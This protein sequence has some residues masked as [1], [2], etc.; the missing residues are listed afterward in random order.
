MNTGL[1]TFRREITR[2]SS[3][4]GDPWRLNDFDVCGGKFCLSPLSGML[5]G[6]MALQSGRWQ[7][8]GTSRL[9]SGSTTSLAQCKEWELLVLIPDHILSDR[10]FG[11]RCE[12]HEDG[13][14]SDSEVV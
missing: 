10:L 5:Q 13:E 4:V 12:A 8:A 14:A 11:V 3:H 2:F 6:R 1:C 7:D 9:S